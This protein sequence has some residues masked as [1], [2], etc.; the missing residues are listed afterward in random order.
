MV[1]ITPAPTAL[2]TQDTLMADTHTTPAPPMPAPT[3]MATTPTT[4]TV[5]SQS[6][7]PLLLWRKP[8]LRSQQQRSNL[9]RGT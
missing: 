9:K 1:A 8:L 4:P 3:P 6:L 2:T 5:V 7:P